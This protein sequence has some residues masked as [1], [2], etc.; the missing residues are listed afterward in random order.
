[1]GKLTEEQNYVASHYDSSIFQFESARLEKY[2]PLEF[3]ITCRRLEHT[4]S[5]RALD[6]PPELRMR[7][8]LW[9]ST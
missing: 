9:I 3:S 8:A 5:S 2:C 7:E 6:E 1:M 4:F